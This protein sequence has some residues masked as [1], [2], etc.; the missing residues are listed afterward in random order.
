MRRGLRTGLL[1]GSFNPA[2]AGHRRV[3]EAAL[4]RLGLDEVWWLVSPQ[5]P[6]KAAAGMAPY[7]QRVAVARRVAIHPRIRVSEAE[8][9]LGTRYT[10]DTLRALRQRHPNRRF[11]WIMGADN[12]VQI[13][14]WRAWPTLFRMVPVA[15]FNRPTYS[16]G[17]LSGVAARRFA[18]HRIPE[19][20]GKTLAD[21][22]PPAWVFLWG[23]ND[24]TSATAIRGAT[25]RPQASPARPPDGR[26]SH[27]R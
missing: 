7:S 9:E 21:R 14:R 10:V 5:N 22:T 1:G 2:H 3:S 15:V 20:E 16:F 8:A 13:T 4:A 18:R 12:L 26:S 24:P 27:T 19:R 17:A 6:L 11:V 23:I 25:H